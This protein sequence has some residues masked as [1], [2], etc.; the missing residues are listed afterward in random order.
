MVSAGLRR[1]RAF[2]LEIA[3]H[4][5]LEPYLEPS[6]AAIG[7][8][9]LVVVLGALPAGR[10]PRDIELDWPDLGRVVVRDGRALWVAPL[11]SV[12]RGTLAAYLASPLLALVL[13]QRGD[14]ILHASVVAVDD[15]RAV[16]FTGTSGA[17]KS[18]TA[19]L[20]AGTRALMSD[21]IAPLRVSGSQVV[22]RAGP[23]LARLDARLVEGWPG[24]R[25]VGDEALGG[26]AL[27]EWSARLACGEPRR[28]VA[29]YGLDDGPTV[30]V[31]SRSGTAA[32]ATLLTGSFCLDF[33]GTRK[34]AERLREAA[35]I[36]RHVM[37]RA[38]RRPRTADAHSSIREAIIADV[39][40]L[41]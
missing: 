39:A 1:Y 31:E 3:S 15:R 22:T 6:P 37:V 30:D 5:P 14:F 23:T 41:G 12:G 8:P 18:T 17:G 19:A 20:L 36:G 9:D 27:F 34:Q 24:L 7:P 28:L 32:V 10:G 2:G 25:R 21:D 29:L 38:L 4:A 40:A 11:P 26:K 33:G 13:E 35:A 16:A